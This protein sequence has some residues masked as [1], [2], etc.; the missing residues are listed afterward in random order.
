MRLTS[1]IISGISRVLQ[2]LLKYFN[3]AAILASLVLPSAG[4]RP[5]IFFALDLN[6]LESVMLSLRI[7][8]RTAANFRLFLHNYYC[9]LLH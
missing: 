1:K 5:V 4:V 3:D 7:F 8:C 9:T 6:D 2:K